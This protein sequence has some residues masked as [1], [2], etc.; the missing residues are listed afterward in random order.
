MEE[1]QSLSPSSSSTTTTKVSFASSVAAGLAGLRRDDAAEMCAKKLLE[2]NQQQRG[3]GPLDLLLR[4]VLRLPA[5]GGKMD[6]VREEDDDA[7]LPSVLASDLEQK[8]DSFS[9]VDPDCLLKFLSHLVSTPTHTEKYFVLIAVLMEKVLSWRLVSA[10]ALALEIGELL[11]ADPALAAAAFDFIGFLGRQVA[12]ATPSPHGAAAAAALLLPTLTT[13]LL[14]AVGWTEDFRHSLKALHEVT[15]SWFRLED[16]GHLLSHGN[17][18]AVMRT[19]KKSLSS[20]WNGSRDDHHD[21]WEMVSHITKPFFTIV[22]SAAVIKEEPGLL[23]MTCNPNEQKKKV[24]D[25]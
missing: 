20:R 18:L 2:E 21:A 3:G 4:S 15:S 22:P 13:L 7:L 1:S 11:P 6:E 16:A 14:D 17:L 12:P 8:K 23:C 10:E 9:A 25:W 5:D 19:L 24:P